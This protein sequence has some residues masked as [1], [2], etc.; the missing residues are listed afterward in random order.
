MP[1]TSS[2]PPKP[3]TSGVVLVG[4]IAPY[5]GG[6]AQY[7]SHL[8]D[9]LRRQLPH[10]HCISFSRQYPAWLYP[11]A[12]EFEPGDGGR[13]AD[14]AYSIDSMNPLTWVRTA[15]LILA[16][17]PRLVVF[18]WWTVFWL[19]TFLTISWLVRRRNVRTLLICHNL[20]DHDSG[21][22]KRAAGRWGLS[23]GNAFLVH[24]SEHAAALREQRP[25]APVRQHPIPTYENYPAAT[26][27]L[28]SRGRLELLFFG[29]IRPY[30]GLDVLFE[31]LRRIDDCEVYL[32]VVG[33]AWTDPDKIAADARTVPNVELHLSYV[34]AAESA[35]YFARADFVVL[36]YRTATGSA[37]AAVAHHYGKPLI[38]SRAGGL[39]D[40]VQD[41]ETG[42]LVE[43]GDAD[44][45]AEAIRTSSRS[46]AARMGENVRLTRDSKDWDSMAAEL[47][48]LG[49][50]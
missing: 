45:L 14:V 46:E 50:Q 39:V 42:L 32:T 41:A 28:P 22:M 36:P 31:A 48:E 37:V 27:R 38:A 30:K 33:E 13:R 20:V 21:L 2:E 12:D 23:I 5:R 9:A 47:I 11:G 6:I 44:A 18:Q 19:P 29:F 4:P 1:V 15:R 34:D 25:G 43:P 17:N 24:S 49:R 35:E 8:L 26:G 16:T 3:P 7:T 10:A 40:V